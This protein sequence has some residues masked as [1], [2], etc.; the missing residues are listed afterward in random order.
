MTHTWSSI[1]E[2]SSALR[3]AVPSLKPKRFRGVACSVEV[4]EVRPKPSCIHRVETTPK[5]MRIRLCTAWTA[6]CGSSAHA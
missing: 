3:L 4:E 2:A 6:T 5:P 1:A